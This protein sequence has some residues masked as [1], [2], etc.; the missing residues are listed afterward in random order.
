MELL[1]VV[2]GAAA[3][4]ALSTHSAGQYRPRAPSW[5]GAQESG[6]NPYTI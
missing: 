1:F 5:S 2:A 6:S 4:Y 3:W